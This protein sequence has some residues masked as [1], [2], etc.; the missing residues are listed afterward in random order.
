[1][2]N[3]NDKIVFA[4]PAMEWLEANPIGNG[5]IGAMVFGKPQTDRLQLNDDTLW[6]GKKLN[7]D[8]P[9]ALENL[10]EIRKLLLEGENRKAL[11]LCDKYLLGNPHRVRSYQE[12]GN[13]YIEEEEKQITEYIR[14]LDMET[15]ILTVKYK[16]DNINYKREYFISAP[17]DSLFIKITADAPVINA[18]ISIKREKDASVSAIYNKLILTG[19]IIDQKEDGLGL[20]GADMRFAAALK[21]ESDGDIESVGEI[22]HITNASLLTICLCSCTDY[23]FNELSLDSGKDPRTVCLNKIE[24][25]N[26]NEY[27][28]Y[29]DE[30]IKEHSELYNRIKLNIK[31]DSLDE[32]TDVILSK[33]REGQCSNDLI[34]TMFNFGR[35]LLINSSRK[36]ATLPANLQGIWGEGLEMPWNADFHTNINLQMNYWPATVCNLPET[37]ELL[38]N[39]IE[40]IAV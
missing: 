40:K 3:K 39:F 23:D 6:A 16:A 22:L 7:S 17:A 25:L 19:Q 11:E 32:N 35:Y 21:S 4:F 9:H 15:G 5:H 14:S 37:G 38:N 29:M 28:N 30:H 13:L 33:A 12:L 27:C 18:K 8:A 34:E 1:M 31:N 24:Q 10:P 20:G 36:P 2:K 26:L